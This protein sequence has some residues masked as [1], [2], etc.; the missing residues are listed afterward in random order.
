MY[1]KPSN[2]RPECTSAQSRTGNFIYHF[3]FRMF[4]YVKDKMCCQD[5]AGSPMLSEQS[6]LSLVSIQKEFQFPGLLKQ[7]LSEA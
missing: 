4:Q 2:Y 5:S 6:V 3:S 1:L 7:D